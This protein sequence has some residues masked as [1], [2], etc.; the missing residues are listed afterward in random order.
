MLA[1]VS[2]ALVAAGIRIRACA[3]SLSAALLLIHPVIYSF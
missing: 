1:D 3:V 2:A